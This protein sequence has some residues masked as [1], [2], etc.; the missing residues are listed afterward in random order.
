MC[1][2]CCD[3]KTLTYLD[4]NSRRWIVSISQGARPLGAF[5]RPVHFKLGNAPQLLNPI[6]L[7]HGCPGPQKVQGHHP[8]ALSFRRTKVQPRTDFRPSLRSIEAQFSP[9]YPF[10]LQVAF[11]SFVYSS[12]WPLIG[13]FLMVHIWT[14]PLFNPFPQ[15]STPQP[16]STTVHFS[17]SENL[18]SSLIWFND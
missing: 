15:P 17:T 5:P 4:R 11:Q 7:P 3:I 13:S 10:F 16:R 14:W 1:R 12:L 9:G 8:S 6:K 18:N 2:L